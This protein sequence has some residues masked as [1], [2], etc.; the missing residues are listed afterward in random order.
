[1]RVVWLTEAS[2]P[3]CDSSLLVACR[4]TVWEWRPLPQALR[5]MIL[6]G[7]SAKRGRILSY[8]RVVE[9]QGLLWK[10]QTLGKEVITSE[11]T[12]T[13]ILL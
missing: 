8:Q 4:D 12:D 2:L 3:G 7:L 10:L 9:K 6:L 13:D 11:V 1:M 5:M